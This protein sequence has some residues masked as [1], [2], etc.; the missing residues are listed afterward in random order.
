MHPFVAKENESEIRSCPVV[1]VSKADYEILRANP[2]HPLMR[3]KGKTCLFLIDRPYYSPTQAPVPDPAKMAYA[4]SFETTAKKM[5]L[6]DFEKEK[7]R[8]PKETSI[9]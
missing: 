7:N 6:K 9:R 5:R 8:N 2:E 4:F 1:A 3:E